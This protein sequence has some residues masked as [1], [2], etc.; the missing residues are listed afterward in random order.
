MEVTQYKL[1]SDADT[2]DA[3]GTNYR[4][5]EVA[6]LMFWLVKQLLLN[7]AVKIADYDAITT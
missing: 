4:S 7:S 1:P 2:T 6:P 5:A 3:W